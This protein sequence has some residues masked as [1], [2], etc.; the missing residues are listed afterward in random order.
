MR[1]VEGSFNG[2]IY[3][4]L[5]FSPD[6]GEG[7]QYSFRES[8]E[9]IRQNYKYSPNSGTNVKY[10]KPY[11]LERDGY[12]CKYCKIPLRLNNATIDHYYPAEFWYIDDIDLYNSITNLVTSCNRCNFIKGKKSPV[13]FRIY[14][15]EDEKLHKRLLRFMLRTKSKIKLTLDGTRTLRGKHV[16]IDMYQNMNRAERKKALHARFKRYN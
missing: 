9:F 16:G 6:D 8:E 15:K 11:L 13:G 12:K 4:P 3:G 14:S 1:G 7:V 2:H 5:G 10:I